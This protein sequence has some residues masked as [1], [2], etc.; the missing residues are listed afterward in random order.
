MQEKVYKGWIKIVDELHSLGTNW[1]SALFISQWHMR[2][3]ACVKA[4][5]GHFVH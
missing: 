2:L 4:K 1:I 5:G 3:R